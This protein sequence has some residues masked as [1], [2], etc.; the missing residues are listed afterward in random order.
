MRN[1]ARNRA[2]RQCQFVLCLKQRSIA[3]DGYETMLCYS[4]AQHKEYLLSSLQIQSSHGP[5]LPFTVICKIGK[6]FFGMK[7]LSYIEFF[8][9]NKKVYCW[10]IKSRDGK[11][12][13]P[14]KKTSAGSY[15]GFNY[16]I[17]HPGSV[18][19]F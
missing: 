11:R 5:F 10:T 18:D 1:S 16:R 4:D 3:V 19:L 13:Y 15:E 9:N 14:G 12:L 6:E 17:L 8:R 2:S 7:K